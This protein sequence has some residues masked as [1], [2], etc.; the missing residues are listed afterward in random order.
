MSVKPE[1]YN[2]G[3]LRLRSLVS[4]PILILA[5]S[6]CEKQK[7]KATS[8]S[9]I[10][11]NSAVFQ[12][13]TST[14]LTHQ[15]GI[16]LTRKIF[17]DT[18]EV[19]ARI[20]L[21]ERRSLLITTPAAGRLE[22]VFIRSSDQAVKAGD[23][24][25]SLYSPELITAQREYLLL[26]E[27]PPADLLLEEAASRLVQMGMTRGQIRIIRRMGKPL[28][29]IPIV[30][31]KSGF[32][33]QTMAQGSGGSTRSGE[34]ATMNT[35]GTAGNGGGGAGMGMSGATEAVPPGAGNGLVG[36][37]ALKTGAYLERGSPL[38]TLNDLSV[39][40]VSLALPIDQAGLF[41]EGDSIHL[42][43]PSLGISTTA[44]MDYLESRIS[45]INRTL[46]AKAYLPNPGFKLKVGT[47]GKAHLTPRLDSAWVLPR[48][49]VYSQGEK[50]IVWSQSSTDSAAYKAREVRLGR[51]GS[52]WVEVTRGLAPGEI[53]AEVASLLLDRDAIVNALVLQDS[54]LEAIPPILDPPAPMSAHTTGHAA[55][56]PHANSKASFTLSPEQEALAGITSAKARIWM[57]APSTTLRATTR[58][59]DRSS[60][61]IPTRVDGT[62][63]KVR[64][65]RPGE[66]VTKGEILAEIRSDALMS[67]QQEFLL[68]T[69]QSK[70]LPDRAMRSS[71]IQAA[72][73]R[74][75]VLGMNE[76]QVNALLNAGKSNPQISII[77]PRA[78]IILE[79][80]VQAGQYVREGTS[81]FTIGGGDRIWVETWMLPAEIASYPEGTDAWVE[82]EGLVGMPIRGKLEHMRQEM[83]VTGTLAIA[84]IGIP[85]PEG[86]ILSG[87][88][89]SVTLKQKGRP[90]LAIPP[91]ALLESST[92][93]MAWLRIGQNQFVPRMV[94][95]GLRTPEAVEILEG[96]S[97][98]EE[99][100]VTGAY[101]LNSEWIV[102]QGAGKGHGGH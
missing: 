76:L 30:S 37:V 29:R 10:P 78:G 38:A 96:I 6:T 27:K 12:S 2:R 9:P 47:L 16:Q 43:L 60:E 66:K 75:V 95:I 26:N 19:P 65:R 92:S 57:I 42:S 21:D 23:P 46:T 68:A 25:A 41:R 49:A 48:S 84:H 93:T 99:V 87:L 74:L 32:V 81:L 17:E 83:S 14:V 67:A 8:S 85:N 94:K 53:V 22:E 50:W 45:D 1:N 11:T 36:L 7:E 69:S 40:T 33:V 35:G 98:G 61:R 54:S 73:R 88:Q 89:A 15:K 44:R 18:L 102:R 39:I 77:S 71:Q 82:I 58:F 51:K 72:R 86:K 28:D 59:D 3:W 63:D 62:V 79:V 5:L 80:N 31:P 4:L 90:A 56:K 24:I 64:I 13:P 100:V 91:S 101:L 55:G 34:D 52:H 20:E 97:P 70:T